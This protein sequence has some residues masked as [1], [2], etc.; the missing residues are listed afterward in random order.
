VQAPAL[1]V[2]LAGRDLKAAKR[3]NAM[4]D[5]MASTRTW[6]AAQRKA[7]LSQVVTYTRGDRSVQILA[8]FERQLL[9]VSDG[10]GNTK[11]ERA[12]ADFAFTAADLDFGAGPIEP[13]NGDLVAV[14]Y[15]AGSKIFRV[16]PVGSEPAWRYVDAFQTSV[17]VHTKFMG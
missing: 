8:T 11:I 7:F 12:D 2:P 6:L 4:S 10:Q 17:M 14:A 13:A 1:A 16:T 5:L 9:K 3:K 15:A